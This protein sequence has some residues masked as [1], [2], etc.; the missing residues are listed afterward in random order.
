MNNLVYMK[1][2]LFQ[3]DEPVGY[4]P[5]RENALLWASEILTAPYEI[6]ELKRPLHYNVEWCRKWK[7]RDFPTKVEEVFGA[8]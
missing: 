2:A 7:S 8:W 1:F 4:F 3:H 6:E 5:T